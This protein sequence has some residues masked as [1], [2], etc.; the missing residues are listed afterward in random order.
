MRSR[1]EILTGWLAAL[2]TFTNCSSEQ[3]A[4]A[5]AEPVPTSAPPAEATLFDSDDLNRRIDSGEDVFLL[6]VRNPDELEADGMIEGAVNI[7]IDQLEARLAEV[8]K[9]RSI[10]TYCLHGR[11]ASLAATLLKENGYG[12]TVEFG[13]MEEWEEKGYPI[14]QPDAD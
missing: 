1:R 10:A 11:R 7:P 2:V 12:N 6:D 4:E 5:E 8:P 13:G 9:D 14:V 3:P